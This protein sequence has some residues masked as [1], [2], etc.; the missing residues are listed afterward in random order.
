M[1]M[2]DQIP[3]DVYRY[4]LTD[5]RP[6]AQRGTSGIP[7]FRKEGFPRL[8]VIES[9]EID[10]PTGVNRVRANLGSQLLMM[11]GRETRGMSM[12]CND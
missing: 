6:F 5:Q 11:E 9:T 1:C 10:S 2:A 7:P 3:I 12:Y 8:E 4:L